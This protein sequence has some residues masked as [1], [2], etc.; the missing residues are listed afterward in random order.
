MIQKSNLISVTGDEDVYVSLWDNF[1][2]GISHKI[3]LFIVNRKDLDCQVEIL[4]E[5]CLTNRTIEKIDYAISVSFFGKLFDRVKVE[6]AKS[7]GSINDFFISPGNK[8]LLL[9][10]IYKDFNYKKMRE[11]FN[12]CHLNNIKV[13]C[14]I[15]RDVSSLSWLITKQFLSY[16]SSSHK[17]GIF[18]FRKVGRTSH[19]REILSKD[20]LWELYDSKLFDK[21][22]IKQ[23]IYKQNWEHIVFHGH[24]KEDNL[25]LGEYTLCGKNNS[26]YGLNNLNPSCGYC[27]QNCFKDEEKLIDPKKIRSKVLTL[28]SCNNFPFSDLSLYNEKYNLGLNAIDGLFQEIYLSVGVHNTDIYE[29]EKFISYFNKNLYIPSFFNTIQGEK[30]NIPFLIQIGLPS[31]CQELY[32]EKGSD[33]KVCLEK[34]HIDIINRLYFY[35]RTSLLEDNHII[36]KRTSTLL[37]KIE[38]AF[39]FSSIHEHKKLMSE[40]LNRANADSNLIMKCLLGSSQDKL[41]DYYDYNMSRS[42]TVKKDFGFTCSCGEK[43]LYTE[44]HGVINNTLDIDSNFCYRCGDQ[45]FSMKNMPMISVHVPTKIKQGE[46]LKI[47][48]DIDSTQDG[49]IYIANIL[50]NYIEQFRAHEGVIKKFK[51][52][53]NKGKFVYEDEITLDFTIPCQ[54]YYITII[55]VQ[56]LGIS[57]CRANFNIIK[58]KN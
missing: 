21:T 3:P 57:I 53:K 34:E 2:R 52:I 32:I 45:Y 41:Y 54:A 48:C 37:L 39:Q 4:E 22:D 12:Y 29:V 35:G 28:L 10:G 51:N 26:I 11:I 20:S 50:P 46:K 9:M 17:N 58:E 8:T 19:I 18:T 1:F 7:W 40:L 30:N 5:Y 15:G 49:N 24:G 25:N 47:K 33:S 56:N 6:I 16:Q 31:V 23:L 44:Y 38:N 27:N 42:L 13:Y 36:K 55:M 43:S 14:L